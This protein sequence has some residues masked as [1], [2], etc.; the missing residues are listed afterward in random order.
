MVAYTILQKNVLQAAKGTDP[1]SRQPSLPHFHTPAHYPEELLVNKF[2][3]IER[4]LPQ[5]I[6]KGAY[7][8]SV[9]SNPFYT[10]EGLDTVR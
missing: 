7:L 5:G 1:R 2:T 9:L 8:K 6:S 4:A 10:A 3:N